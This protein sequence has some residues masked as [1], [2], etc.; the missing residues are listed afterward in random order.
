MFVIDGV[1]LVFSQKVNQ[2][3]HFKDSHAVRGEQHFQ[4][5][6]E[7]LK[8]ANVRENIVA[9]DNLHC[10]FALADI[11]CAA[12]TK[13]V[14]DCPH[15]GGIRGSSNIGGWLNAQGMDVMFLERP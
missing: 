8:V 3:G 6:S 12:L 4:S 13:E 14:V 11:S 5:R 1:E 2:I 15:S 7:I 9:N 10:S